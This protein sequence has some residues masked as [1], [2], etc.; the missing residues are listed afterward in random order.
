MRR[1]VVLQAIARR[2][3][4]PEHGGIPLVERIELLLLMRSVCPSQKLTK[5]I[6]SF[7]NGLPEFRR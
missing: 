7:T 6:P 4:V 3:S 2:L 5:V 1:R